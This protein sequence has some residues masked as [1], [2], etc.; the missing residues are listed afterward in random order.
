MPRPICCHACMLE[1]MRF[2][3]HLAAPCDLLEVQALGNCCYIERVAMLPEIVPANPLFSVTVN[4]CLIIPGRCIP[5]FPSL[6]LAV[7]I[8]E[9]RKL[10]S[11]FSISLPCRAH[12]SKSRKLH[13]AFSVS[14]PCREHV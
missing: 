4:I 8:F 1:T 7:S 14:P 12:I 2:L 11:A 13:S 6:R 10:Y 3:F 5:R 9:S